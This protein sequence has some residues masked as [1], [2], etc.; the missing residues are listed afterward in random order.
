MEWWRSFN[1]SAVENIGWYFVCQSILHHKFRWHF[2]R[3]Q[4]KKMITFVDPA[5]FE[6]HRWFKFEKE[7]IQGIFLIFPPSNN[8]LR[9]SQ[10]IVC[11]A[12]VLYAFG[13]IVLADDFILKIYKWSWFGW[14]EFNL[15]QIGMFDHFSVFSNLIR[16]L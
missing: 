2:L 14:S 8:S 10:T 16:H 9:F 15:R 1:S 12:F 3:A 5:K 13:I 7:N 4:S 6:L 11:A